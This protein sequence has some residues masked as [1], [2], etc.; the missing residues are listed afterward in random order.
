MGS[1]RGRSIAQSP[2]A[3]FFAAEEPL[4]APCSLACFPLAPLGDPLI[5]LFLGP[6]G[7]LLAEEPPVAPLG[8]LLGGL[9]G[10]FLTS[11]SPPFRGHA[12]PMSGG[13]TPFFRPAPP[14]RRD[15][16]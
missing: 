6:G 13:G 16:Q 10:T 15:V 1:F 2:T 11:S 5:V 9:G 4:E 14:G 8:V 7:G 3:R 12:S